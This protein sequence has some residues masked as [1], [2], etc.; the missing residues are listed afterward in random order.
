[1]EQFFG[2]DWGSALFHSGAL[3]PLIVKKEAQVL[4]I[5]GQ[6]F[7]NAVAPCKW[8]LNIMIGGQIG[9]VWIELG[10]ADLCPKLALKIAGSGSKR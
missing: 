2:W 5:E 6:P 4:H 8:D 7:L 9:N 3:Y 1:V 10:G